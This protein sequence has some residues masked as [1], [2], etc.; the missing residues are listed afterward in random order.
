[1]I[2]QAVNAFGV[3]AVDFDIYT[4][5]GGVGDFVRTFLAF[6]FIYSGNHLRA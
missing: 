1:M 4:P 3:S 6:A 2:V 5:G